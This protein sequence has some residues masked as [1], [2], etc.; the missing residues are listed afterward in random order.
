[1]TAIDA[2]SYFGLAAISLLTLNILIGL[3]LS[4]KYNPV[5][6]WPHRRINTLKL[7]NWTGFAALAVALVHPVLILFSSTAHFHF[8]DIAYPLNAPKQPYINTLGALALYLLII[9][10]VTSYFRF[11]I[12]RKI[13]KPLHFTTYALFALY[14]VHALLT[15][16]NLKDAPLDPFDAEKVFVELCI[17]VVLAAIVLR[18]RWQLRQ[19]PA[20][21]HRPKAARGSDESARHGVEA[22]NG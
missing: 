13:W 21:E 6:K 5:R 9:T 17:V 2:S 10:V 15:D 1:M 8:I 16:P 14:A 22:R 20:R 12:G 18:I 19:P 11:Q 4:T 3:L 7:H